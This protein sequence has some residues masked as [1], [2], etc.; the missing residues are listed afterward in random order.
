[1][2]TPI[3]GR[4]AAEVENAFANLSAKFDSE[5]HER[6]ALNQAVQDLMNKNLLLQDEVIALRSATEERE[7]RQHGRRDRGEGL[8]L[9]ATSGTHSGTGLGVDTRILGKPDTFDGSKEKWRDWSVVFASYAT[10]V[11]TEIKVGMEKVEAGHDQA[12]SNLNQKCA[13]AA[14]ELHHML[15][16]LTK[17]HALDQV[18]NAGTGEGY[19]DLIA[20]KPPFSPSGR[21]PRLN[22]DFSG[23]TISKIE[24]F[25]R[26]VQQYE[27]ATSE[28]LTDSVKIGLLV[29]KIPEP[30]LKDHVLMN[31]ERLKTWQ[32]EIE[33]IRKAQLSVAPMEVG[34]AGKD[35]R[36]KRGGKKCDS[37]RETR[38]CFKCGK[39][40]NLA[41]NCNSKPKD[42]GGKGHTKGGG[43]G[44]SSNCK[45]W[46]KDA[47]DSSKQWKEKCSN[48]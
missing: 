37:V 45:N 23:E 18:L 33:N 7:F 21:L 10:L 2:A 39:K 48:C 40:G 12:L 20:T 47:K 1:M 46:N 35:N 44:F 38:D 29:S 36:G 24:S 14:H 15:L 28:S 8:V 26:A 22:F 3:A 5:I 9:P 30:M 34:Y 13:K 32:A 16:H 6:Q 4:S 27:R 43:R 17:Q 11:N 25:E 41:A 31:V 19:G 42:S